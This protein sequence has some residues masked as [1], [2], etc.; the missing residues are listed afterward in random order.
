MRS[1]IAERYPALLSPYY[2]R[3][4]LGSF[5]SVG[6]TQFI[7]LGQGWLIFELTGSALQLGYLGVA[8]A[9][10]NIA[11]TLAGGVIADRFDK[12]K[13]LIVTSA[14]CAALLAILAALVFTGVVAVWHVLLISALFSLVTGLDWPARVAIY[15]YLV[16]RTAMMSAVALNAFI[17]QATRMAIPALGGLLI[18]W[19]DTS[20]VFALASLGFLAMFWVILTLPVRVPAVA[21]EPPW[22]QLWQGMH[23]IWH[24]PLFLWLLTAT[25]VG[26]FFCNA[27]VQIMPVFADL[28]GGNEQI[29]GLLLTIGGVGSIMGTLFMGSF[30]SHHRLGWIM[31]ASAVLSVVT[32]TAFAMAAQAGSLAV[33]LVFAFLAAASSSVFMVTSMS[34][35]QISVPDELRG[36]VMGIHTIGYSLI[37]LGGLFLGALTERFSAQGAVAIGCAVYL[38]VLIFIAI[39]Q[40]E[41]RRL[42]QRPITVLSAPDRGDR[43]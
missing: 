14:A 16:E 17:W 1:F 41:V 25:F 19:F 2:R 10:P 35:L 28:L 26:M 24:H 40:P 43:R 13:I 5:A 33:T 42:G 11:M 6:A 21:A 15:P 38:V 8:A 12:R 18:A 9:L 29:F 36:R 22:Q 7:T 27:Y 32:T 34:V 20:L 23:Y 37:P 39:S 30:H 4:W 3:Y 31:L